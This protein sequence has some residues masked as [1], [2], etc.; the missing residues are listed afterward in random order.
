MNDKPK[1]G[2]RGYLRIGAAI[3]GG[4]CIGAGI[5]IAYQGKTMPIANVSIPAS[6]VLL[7][8]GLILFG[9]ALCRFTKIGSDPPS[10]TV[11]YVVTFL[12]AVGISLLLSYLLWGRKFLEAPW[13]QINQY[14]IFRDLLTIFLA[15]LAGLGLLV[16]LVLRGAIEKTVERRIGK[17]TQRI[18]KDRTLFMTNLQRVMGYMFWQLFKVEQ[19]RGQ[20]KGTKESDTNLDSSNKSTETTT[21]MLLNMAIERTRR[22]LEYAKHLPETESEYKKAIHIC[23][24]NL[25]YFLAEAT[26]VKGIALTKQRKEQALELTK[27]IL[28]VASKQDYP[29]EYHNLQESCAYALWHLTE[30]GDTI[31]KQKARDIIH[32]LLADPYIPFAWRKRIKRKWVTLLNE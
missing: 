13:W 19:T 26:R 20:G 24:S 4:V 29:K 28:A 9:I 1:W 21:R 5:L 12:V 16:F 3:A 2:I 8:I 23:K 22:S 25:I 6:L 15:I 11:W 17:A 10:A 31:S 32:G 18:E 27:E 14:N 30:E 7:V